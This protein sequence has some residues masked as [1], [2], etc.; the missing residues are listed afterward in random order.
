MAELNINSWTEPDGTEV[1][2]IGDGAQQVFFQTREGKLMEVRAQKG[3]NWVT[4]KFPNGSDSVLDP[5]R[6]EIKNF[7]D[8][9]E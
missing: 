2:V 3:D 8:I 6:I 1:S 4:R 5:N 9:E 7:N